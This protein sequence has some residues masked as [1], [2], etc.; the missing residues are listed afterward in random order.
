MRLEDDPD[1]SSC[2]H[3]LTI[4]NNIAALP[5]GCG[6]LRVV[7]V[8][9]RNSMLAKGR[10]ITISRACSATHLA[11]PLIRA[12]WFSRTLGKTQHTQVTHGY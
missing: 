9:R 8:M 4:L 1:T 3:L 10:G 11:L 2:W 5:C 12:R 7:G 6:E